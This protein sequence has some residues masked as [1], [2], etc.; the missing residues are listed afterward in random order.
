[1]RCFALL[2]AL[3]IKSESVNRETPEKGLMKSTLELFKK[4]GTLSLIIYEGIGRIQFFL[5]T[6][7]QLILLKNGASLGI[8][9]I[10][11]LISIMLQFLIQRYSQPIIHKFKRANL[12]KL[13][14]ILQA[15]LIT[16]LL[17]NINIIICVSIILVYSCIP[18][19]NQAVN[20]IKHRIIE[21][22]Q[23]STYISVVSLGSLVF[24]T[25]VFWMVGAIFNF[26]NIFGII[27]LGATL[28]LCSL[29]SA[30]SIQK[31]VYDE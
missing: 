21:D 16:L 8:L 25:V 12:L 15:L 13:L 26:S 23:R 14:P 10:I 28:A 2:C 17:S 19:K 5:P 9:T 27:A 31:L 4:E 3:F 7:Y 24:N 22:Y 1:M 11:N 18:I 20:E 29:F 6:I 30:N